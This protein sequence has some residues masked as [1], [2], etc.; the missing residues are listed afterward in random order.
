MNWYNIVAWANENTGFMMGVLTALY[1]VATIWIVWESRRTNKLQANA[2]RQAADL[3][4][5]RNRPYL[6]FNINAT[7]KTHSEYDATWYFE[8][9]ASNVGRTSAHDIRITTEPDFST[10][11][12]YG[13]GNE[14]KYRTPTMLTDRISILPPGHTE[15]E[16]LGP[17]HFLY[18][19]LGGEDLKFK[20][21]LTYWSSSGQQY[22][23]DYTIDL[24][25]RSDRMG[26]A[27]AMESL[28]F[29][30]VELLSKVSEELNQLNL[31]LNA[32]DRGRMYYSITP[33]ELSASQRDLLKKISRQFE[34]S[35]SKE[36]VL[37]VHLD[38]A[39]L[40]FVG[41]QESSRLPVIP[42]DVESLCRAGLLLGRYDSGTLFCSVAP[43]AKS[44]LEKLA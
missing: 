15:T 28:R 1:V 7:M 41:G 6:V 9:S 3:E 29:R 32:P 24:G 5:A 13:Q 16:E 36:A 21:F 40:I 34:A 25:E 27:D 33:D 43:A 37:S 44:Y 12:G 10:P 18:E 17:T 14:L 19:Q 20:V 11:V 30:E 23:D 31:T 22:K 38:G 2:I 26:S 8:A 35:Q 39:D 42:T 4:V